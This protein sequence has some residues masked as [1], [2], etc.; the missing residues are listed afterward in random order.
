MGACFSNKTHPAGSLVTAV[1]RDADK[2]I[3]ENLRAQQDEERKII[4]CLLLGAGECGKCFG[5]GTLILMY[6]GTLK[7][8]RRTAYCA[9]M[10]CEG[11]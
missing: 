9:C 8:V 4:K 7:K 11:D 5:E 3:E 2:R 10:Q 6:D 1:Q